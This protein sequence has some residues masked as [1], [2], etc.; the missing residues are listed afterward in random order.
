MH[1]EAHGLV[2]GEIYQVQEGPAATNMRHLPNVATPT[3]GRDRRRGGA[4]NSPGEEPMASARHVCSS[5]L[6][7]SSTKNQRRIARV[8]T[9]ELPNGIVSPDGR[10]AALITYSPNGEGQLFTVLELASGRRLLRHSETPS[11]EY[12]Y[13]EHSHLWSP[14]NRLW[15]SAPGVFS[16]STPAPER[17]ASPTSGSPPCCRSPSGRRTEFRRHDQPQPMC[18]YQ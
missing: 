17:S 6:Y 15:D 2:A 13:V 11:A 4:P 12:G 3:S 8:R 5:Y 10:Y 7:D 9:D 1:R 18:G 16:S 14:D